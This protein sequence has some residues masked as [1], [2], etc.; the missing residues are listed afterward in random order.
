MFFF[1][2]MFH[3]ALGVERGARTCPAR[4]AARDRETAEPARGGRADRDRRRASHR[5]GT[6]VDAIRPETVR[7]AMARAGTHRRSLEPPDLK[8]PGKIF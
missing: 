6:T 1:S 8:D 3:G 5:G 2:G 4:H 7:V